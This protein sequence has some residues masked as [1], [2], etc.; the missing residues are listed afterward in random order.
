MITS[1]R[2]IKNGSGDR[3]A[4][5]LQRA[6]CRRKRRHARALGRCRAWEVRLGGASV[7]SGCAGLGGEVPESCSMHARTVPSIR[8]NGA[9]RGPIGQPRRAICPDPGRSSAARRFK[10]AGCSA[11]AEP[12]ADL[13]FSHSAGSSVSVARLDLRQA[14]ALNGN[15]DGKAQ[16]GNMSDSSRARS[17]RRAA[18]VR[19]ASTK[20]R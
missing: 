15:G 4:G 2:R 10:T 8:R 5:W 17:R 12:G 9:E 13:R 6:C 1:T 3:G 16:R 14:G 18:P 20:A 11:M 7:L 19:K